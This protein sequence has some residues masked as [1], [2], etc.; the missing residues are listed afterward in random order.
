[1]ELCG[2]VLVHLD[3][4]NFECLCACGWQR[5]GLCS[6]SGGDGSRVRN[7]VEP[8][9]FGSDE[10]CPPRRRR[11]P[12]P[13]APCP[14]TACRPCS[15]PSLQVGISL[16]GTSSILSGEGSRTHVVST[17]QMLM[18]MGLIITS[19]VGRGEVEGWPRWRHIR[20]TT[21]WSCPPH[22]SGDCRLPLS[23][24]VAHRLLASPAPRPRPPPAS[25]PPRP[26]HPLQAVQAAQLTF[27]DFFMADLNIPG[28]KIVGFEGVIGAAATLGLLMPIAYFLP[29][30]GAGGRGAGR[31]QEEGGLGEG[32]R[33]GGGPP[34]A[35]GKYGFL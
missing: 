33:G 5:V 31:G 19:Q 32:W 3:G 18:G 1:M 6:G 29:G 7:L 14:A 8:G 34:Q 30:E 35:V 12:P 13:P 24:Q 10:T 15:P 28:V 27:E 9:V 22:H 11:L 17:Q 20:Y 4:C 21:P 16:V 25:P 2:S 26:P 23:V